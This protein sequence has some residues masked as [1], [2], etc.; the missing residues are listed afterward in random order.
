MRFI[1]PALDRLTIVAFRKPKFVCG[2]DPWVGGDDTAGFASLVDGNGLEGWGAFVP[3]QAFDF[4]GQEVV[5]VRARA[6]ALVLPRRVALRLV[7]IDQMPLVVDGAEGLVRAPE[8][9]VDFLQ[10]TQ[11]RRMRHGFARGEG[12]FGARIEQ[13]VDVLR[14]GQARIGA[15][16]GR[17]FVGI[18]G[19][20]AE[21][22]NARSEQA[23]L[24][25]GA[26]D[27]GPDQRHAAQADGTVDRRLSVEDRLQILHAV[28]R[29]RATVIVIVLD[30]LGLR[31]AGA[32]GCLPSDARRIVMAAHQIFVAVGRGPDHGTAEA[33][34]A[35]DRLPVGG[36]ALLGV[37]RLS[38]L[39][40]I[41]LLKFNHF[42]SSVEFCI[43]LLK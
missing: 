30:R 23:G 33:G 19:I 31:G 18:D 1:A 28:L 16:A 13:Q 25:Q 34:G 36:I 14:A 6:L 41:K 37:D 29:F 21:H 3:D 43:W 11:Q 38:A 17:R 20:G 7:E 12:Q 5:G 22:P 40:G 32:E 4:N 39:V 24:V 26:N 8:T 27:P 9:V 35:P 10:Q 15:D 42:N 2:P